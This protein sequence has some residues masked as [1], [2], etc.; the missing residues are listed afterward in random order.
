ME[1][2]LGASCTA[3]GDIMTVCMQAPDSYM[4]GSNHR[5]PGHAQGRAISGISNRSFNLQRFCCTHRTAS[6]VGVKS[7]AA[8]SQLLVRRTRT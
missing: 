4:I 2:V 8:C 5:P 3:Q 6:L 7:A 1:A